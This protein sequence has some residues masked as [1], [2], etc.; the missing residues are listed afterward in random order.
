M[1]ETI[2]RWKLV[3]DGFTRRLNAV[4]ADQWHNATPCT[5]FTVRQLVEHVITA[6]RMGP[7]LLGASGAIDAPLG[8]DLVSAWQSTRAA[9]LAAYE[10]A[11]ALQ[12][13]VDTP[14]GQ[15]PAEQFIAGPMIGDALIHTWDVARA[16]G[17]DD[18]LPEAACRIQLDMLKA[19]PEEFLR[20]PGLFSAAIA[21]PAGADAQTQLLCYCGRQP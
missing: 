12:K 9:A 8:N 20:Q 14:F 5:E 6:Q 10:T 11:G 17:A 1:S 13:V 21:P 18:T 4:A 2:A 19:V 7:K 15:M 3:T 16:I